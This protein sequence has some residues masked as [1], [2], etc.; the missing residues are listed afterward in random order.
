MPI[1][2]WNIVSESAIAG[3]KNKTE[4]NAFPDLPFTGSQII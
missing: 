1:S 3:F 4:K 2:G